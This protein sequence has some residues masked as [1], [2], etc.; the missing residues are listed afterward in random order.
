MKNKLTNIKRKN[1]GFTLLEL[2]VVVAVMGLISSMAMD[3]YTDNSNQKRY[4]ATKSRLAEIKFAI[5]GDP[6][7]RVG[8]Q[9]VL[10]GFFKDM[11]RLP[12]NLKELT[13][14]LTTQSYPNNGICITNYVADET[15]TSASCSIGW[16]VQTDDVNKWKG[17]YLHNLQS[18]DGDLVFR[19]AWGNSGGANYGWIFSF[20]N[21]G[22]TPPIP[23]GD[24]TVRSIGL[25]R[26]ASTGSDNLFENNYPSVGSLINKVDLNN[27]W[28]LKSK[29]IA[30]PAYCVTVATSTINL[31]AENS[32]ACIDITPALSNIW[33]VF[34]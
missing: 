12:R 20:N 34:P 31:A 19:D 27:I 24:L 1:A 22:A 16:V 21:D 29:S 4:E 33:V 7:M 8:S 18:S 17:P 11:G 15:K 6:M 14:N 5:I 9:A 10:S 13:K 2:V 23:T 30:A 32:T 3:V 26:K 25:N 28:D